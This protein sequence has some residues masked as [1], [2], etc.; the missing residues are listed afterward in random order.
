[1]AKTKIN[2]LNHENQMVELDEKQLLNIVGGG[3]N[4]WHVYHAP[5][6]AVIKRVYKNDGKNIVVHH[7]P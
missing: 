5:S 4:S 7:Y 2:N 1:M 3:A 6:G